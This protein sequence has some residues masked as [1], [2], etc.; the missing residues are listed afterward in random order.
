MTSP[1]IAP[2]RL[3]FGK[4]APKFNEKTLSFGR[5]MLKGVMP[6]DEPRI[7]FREYKIPVSGWGMYDNDRV[8]DCTCASPAHIRMLDTVHTGTMVTP[9][10]GAILAMYSAVSGYDPATGENDN[11]AAITDVL[12]YWQTKGIEGNKILG[13]VQIDHT[14][15]ERVKQAM[16]LFSAVNIGFNVPSSAMDQFNRGQA[17]DV[18]NRPGAIEGGHCV[19]LFGYGAVGDSCVTWGKRQEM[20]W[21]FFMKYCDE[22]YAIINQDW[23]NKTSLL[24]PNGLNLAVLQDDLQAIAA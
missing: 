14:N 4:L 21:N 18:V 8:G 2:S 22:A 1:Y 7:L 16:Y 10:P 17:W 13:W 11:G 24:A 19:P 9:D 20:T 23:I 5:Y 15:I 12:N 3:K 6:Y